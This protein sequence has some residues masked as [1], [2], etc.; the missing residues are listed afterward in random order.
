M[1][2]LYKIIGFTSIFLLINRLCLGKNE[3][4]LR[5]GRTINVFVRY[6]YLGISMKVISY[7]DTER[8]LFKEP[9]NNVFQV[10]S[11]MNVQWTLCAFVCVS[12][13]LCVSCALCY[14]L[15]AMVGRQSI[16]TNGLGQFYASSNEEMHS[17]MQMFISSIALA[18]IGFLCVCINV[19]VIFH[20]FV[21]FFV[22]MG[23]RCDNR[24]I[25]LM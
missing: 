1:T 8:W 23:M 3:S 20:A 13:C 11:T 18:R 21:F 5:V 6:G 10:S 19:V 15:L 16:G 17:R 9:T 25:Q 2:I 14:L 12:V 22:F 4:R 7:N 24:P